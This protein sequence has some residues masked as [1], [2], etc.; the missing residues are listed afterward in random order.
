MC[1]QGTGTHITR[2]MCFPGREHTSLVICA[3]QVGEHISL[4]MWV[5]PSSETQGQSVGLGEKAERKAKE[6]LGTDS[7]RTISKTSRGCRLLI[8][9]KKCF[10]L[11]CPIDEQFL[12]SFFHEFIHQG[13]CL[14]TLAR[15]VHQA[16]GC[17]GNFYFLL[18]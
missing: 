9:H 6:P 11:L 10:V 12:L 1:F 7:H 18:S 15:F 16:C 13:Y 4:G 8:G 14:A 5:S 3:S 2:D 17:T